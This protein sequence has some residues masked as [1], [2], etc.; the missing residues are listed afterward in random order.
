MKENR[1]REGLF[2]LGAEIPPY[3]SIF[4]GILQGTWRQMGIQY[5]QRCGKDIARNFDMFWKVDVLGEGLFDRPWQK[6]RGPEERAKYCLA[7]IQRFLKELSFLS[8]ELVEFFKGMA[9]GAAS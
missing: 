6:R 5:G 4:I 2:R 3:R 1:F 8:P 9:Q 7:Y